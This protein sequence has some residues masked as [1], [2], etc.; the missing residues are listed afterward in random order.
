MS[1][2]DERLV[3]IE[4]LVEEILVE[5]EKID[6]PKTCIFCVVRNRDNQFVISKSARLIASELVIQYS[7]EKGLTACDHNNKW[8]INESVTLS[9]NISHLLEAKSNDMYNSLDLFKVLGDYLDRDNAP[10]QLQKIINTVGKNWI[11]SLNPFDYDFGYLQQVKE[12]GEGVWE[13]LMVPPSHPNIYRTAKEWA[14]VCDCDECQ[15]YWVRK[16]K[17]I[18]EAEISLGN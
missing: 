7:K 11:K 6:H 14:K 1:S 9:Y 8:L 16:N 12:H 13:G 15:E 10:V 3:I 18:E 4:K 5:K 2:S 17:K